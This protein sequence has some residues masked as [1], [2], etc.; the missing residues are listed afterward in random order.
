MNDSGIV[1]AVLPANGRYTV[2]VS[3]FPRTF[4]DEGMLTTTTVDTRVGNGSYTLTLSGGT[5]PPPPRPVVET[6]P[7]DTP[8][9]MPPVGTTPPP[10]V[11]GAQESTSTSGRVT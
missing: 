6:P 9:D 3:S 5:P 7:A 2:G 4:S 11:G 8:P 10:V 1:Y